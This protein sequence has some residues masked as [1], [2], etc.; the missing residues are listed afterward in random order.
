MS[1]RNDNSVFSIPSSLWNKLVYPA[2][3]EVTVRACDENW[4]AS[5]W[6]NELSKTSSILAISGIL[7]FN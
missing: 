4:T 2:L 5:Q 3:M 1:Y 7:L 6:L